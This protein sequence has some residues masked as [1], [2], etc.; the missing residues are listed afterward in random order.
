M[1]DDEDVFMRR[2]ARRLTG[3]RERRGLSVN[4]LAGKAGVTHTTVYRLESGEHRNIQVR[5]LYRLCRAL[6]VT[7]VEF[8]KAY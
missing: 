7:L 4:Q 3:W 2:V 5:T 1:K 8:F 6:D